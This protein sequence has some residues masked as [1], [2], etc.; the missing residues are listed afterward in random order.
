MND[1]LLTVS[2]LAD[3]LKVSPSWIYQRI[4]ARASDRLPHIKIGK[5]LRFELAAVHAWLDRHRRD[6]ENLSVEGRDGR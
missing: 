4:R 2:D 3:R 5:Y 1:E 6:Y